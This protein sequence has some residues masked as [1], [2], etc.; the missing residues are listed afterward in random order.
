MPA[1]L[2]ANIAA[3]EVMREELEANYL[4]KWVLFYGEQFIGAYRD[5][6]DAAQEAVDRFGEGPYLIREVRT[7]PYH[8]PISATIGGRPVDA[9]FGVLYL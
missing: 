5:F 6:Q 2:K 8:I 9:G 3:Y 4:G 1:T 7:T